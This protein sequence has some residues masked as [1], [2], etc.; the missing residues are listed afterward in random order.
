[1]G[2]VYILRSG[3]A[4][5]FKIGRTENDVQDR[6]KHLSTGN[7]L[8]LTLFDVIETDHASKGEKFLHNRL[9]ARRVRDGDAK[10][11]FG[12]TPEI[13]RDEI[14]L[15]RDYIENDVP[16]L[17]EVSKLA[18]EQCEDRWVAPTDV[19]RAKVDE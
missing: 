1:M 9:Q 11:F 6:I 19:A 5:C 4:D 3:E 16:R 14:R 18:A 8:P 13:M 2:Y 17:A 15:A 7:P 12:L 10:E